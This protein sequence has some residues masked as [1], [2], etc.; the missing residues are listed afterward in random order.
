MMLFL[1]YLLAPKCSNENSTRRIS[2]VALLIDQCDL[3]ELA[4]QSAQ[5]NHTGYGVHAFSKA[6]GK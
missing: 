1:G 6:M 4:N 3:E 2:I 5:N